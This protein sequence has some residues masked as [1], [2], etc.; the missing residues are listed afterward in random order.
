MIERLG[1]LVRTDL[2]RTYLPSEM[3]FEYEE[4]IRDESRVTKSKTIE[5]GRTMDLSGVF[6]LTQDKVRSSTIDQPDGE[7]QREETKGRLTLDF[8]R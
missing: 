4:E 6:A 3:D 8:V 1:I 7:I 5:P 2:G